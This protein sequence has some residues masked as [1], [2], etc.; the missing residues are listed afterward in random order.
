[1]DLGLLIQYHVMSGNWHMV[2]DSKLSTRRQDESARAA[3]RYVFGDTSDDGC[4][5]WAFICSFDDTAFCSILTGFCH[6]YTR[7]A[8]HVYRH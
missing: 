6:V 7:L 4:A 8:C 2:W 1:M 3:C 5:C